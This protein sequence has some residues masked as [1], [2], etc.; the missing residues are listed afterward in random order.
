MTNAGFLLPDPGF[1]D[2]LREVT[3]R[4]GTLLAIVTA[5]TA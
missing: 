1:Y 5:I 2:G 4:H 3:R